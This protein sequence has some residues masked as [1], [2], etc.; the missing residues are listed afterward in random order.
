MSSV[1]PLYF[2]RQG[3]LSV[4]SKHCLSTAITEIQKSSR[5]VILGDGAST[6]VRFYF[7]MPSIAG[8]CC[9]GAAVLWTVAPKALI[10][11]G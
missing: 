11:P 3:T 2:G 1:V 10:K 5:A 6:A 4:V 8:L 7:A 9:E